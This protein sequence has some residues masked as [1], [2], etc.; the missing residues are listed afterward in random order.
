MN[1]YYQPTAAPQDT[2]GAA[3]DA[4]T[5]V[6]DMPKNDLAPP[7]DEP[8]NSASE[9]AP[10]EG[11]QPQEAGFPPED[12]GIPALE[13][14]PA[15]KAPTQESPA[16]GAAGQT[17]VDAA[18]AAS[19]PQEAYNAFIEQL[20]VDLGFDKLEEPQKGNLVDSIKERVE[21]RV[22]RTLMTSL[23]KEQTKE[24]NIEVEEKSLSE[25]AIINMLV[26]KAP[27]AS[28][29]IL[30]ALDDLYMEMKEET[31]MLWKAAGAKKASEAEEV[32]DQSQI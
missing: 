26:E 27:N 25:E 19:S 29:A 6:P 18:K 9:P 17:P 28:T 7:A 14:D 30:S 24:L 4:N 8:L 3:D 11:G 13:P 32:A 5:A 2:S 10:L 23:T 22:L 16:T 31:D 12:P 21:A 15:P 20:L 1:D